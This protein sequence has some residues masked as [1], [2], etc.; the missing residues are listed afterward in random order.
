MNAPAGLNPELLAR[1][2]AHTD[3]SERSRQLATESVAALADAGLLRALVPRRSGGPEQELRYV[4]DAIRSCTRGCSSAAW[5]LMVSAA[6]DWIIARFPERTQ[7]DVWGSGELDGV[8]PGSLAPSG[9]IERVDGGFNLS[10]QWPF[11]SGAIHGRWYLL[12]TTDSNGDRP[13]LYHAVVPRSDLELVDDWYALG[14]RGTGSVDLRAEGVFVPEHRVLDT[15]LL[16]SRGTQW[17]RQHATN[18]YRTPVIPGLT[19]MAA[20]VLLG[21]AER[22]FDSAVELMT[23]QSDRYTGKKKVDRPGLHLRLAEARAEIRSAACLLEDTVA[24]L[25]GMASGEDSP[26]V[27]A[28]ARYQAAYGAEMC[29]RAVDRLVTTTGARA[30]FDQSPMQRAVRDL[31]MGGKH[32]MINLDEC[33]L[34]YGRTLVGLD[35][36]GF[37]L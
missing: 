25:E 21:I 4:L 17:A 14:L 37:I 1:L 24:L 28:R 5:V 33:G 30:V 13:H 6:H 15:G 19:T 11:A 22:A 20:T 35:T 10:G 12:G 32:Q 36:K 8:R 7:D 34:V 16:F 2:A 27:R 26:D 23:Q 9:S 31:I 29:R 3:A 18:V